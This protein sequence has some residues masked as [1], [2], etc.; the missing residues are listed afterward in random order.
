[1]K[2]LLIGSNNKHK[3][4]EIK[5]I[6]SQ[7]DIQIVSAAEYPNLPEVVEDKDTIQEN[8]I[9]KAMENAMATGELAIAD[10]TGL[11]IEAL[12]GDPGVYSAR[13]AGEH[14][15]FADNKRKV[16]DLMQGQ[17]NRKACFK[18][19]VALASPG[20][21]LALAEGMVEGEITETEIGSGGFGYDAIFRAKETG[22]TF[23]EMSEEAKNQIS[24]RA[25]ALQKLL[26][27]L[28]SVL[29]ADN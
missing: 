6:L 20:V 10:D 13:F 22:L 2:R 4:V 26:P 21:L 9:K 1:M 25:R 8:A 19:V 7:L 27:I 12:N 11:F 3:I 16:L 18:T 15:S 29:G 17:S 5:S 14:C 24:H 23:G 28:E